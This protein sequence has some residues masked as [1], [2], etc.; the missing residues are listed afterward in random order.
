MYR[1]HAIKDLFFVCLICIFARAIC[2]NEQDGLA[3]FTS[4]MEIKKAT[5]V[6]LLKSMAAKRAQQRQTP[7]VLN[8][9]SELSQSYLEQRRSPRAGE[10]P[11]LGP[12]FRAEVSITTPS[13]TK[14]N[15]GASVYKPSTPSPQI[16]DSLSQN[17]IEIQSD[18]YKVVD[19][20]S[21][22]LPLSTPPLAN[23][24]PYKTKPTIFKDSSVQH[25]KPFVENVLS[26]E[27]SNVLGADTSYFSND[28][29]KENSPFPSFGNQFYYKYSQNT[30]LRPP[31]ILFE[32]INKEVLV[33]GL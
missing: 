30:T 7:I 4:S 2:K 33:S 18:N 25:L 10:Y 23:K 14:F 31:S 16:D 3:L 17:S 22:S 15:G 12:L 9:D 5:L 24:K 11:F 13:P 29:E 28:N 1:V 21:T 8:R 20:S 27:T 32:E 19:E 26:T 6:N